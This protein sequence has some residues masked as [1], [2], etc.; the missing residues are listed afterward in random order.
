M[1]EYLTTFCSLEYGYKKYQR[2]RIKAC[3]VTF[4]HIRR[5]RSSDGVDSIPP[6]PEDSAH[7]SLV[8]D[9]CDI[10]VRLEV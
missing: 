3:S 6:E 1:Y 7:A 8:L 2:S 10:T 9:T 5:L 4:D